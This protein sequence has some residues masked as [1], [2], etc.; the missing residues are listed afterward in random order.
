MSGQKGLWQDD[1][2]YSEGAPPPP[3]GDDKGANEAPTGPTTRCADSHPPLDV[4]GGRVIHGGS[5]TSPKVKDPSAVY[6]GFDAGMAAGIA[7]PWDGGVEV[8]FKVQDRDIPLNHARFKQL[9]TWV[10]EQLDAG[11]TVYAGCIGGHGRTGTFLSA[12]V[13]HRKASDDP[14]AYVRQHYCKKAVESSKQVAYLVSEWGCKSAEPTDHGGGAKKSSWGSSTPTWSGGHSSGVTWN[15]KSKPQ[16]SKPVWAP[17][18]KVSG[19]SSGKPLKIKAQIWG[20]HVI[21]LDW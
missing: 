19:K 1:P 16:K 4:G 11:R 9:V 18:D 21:P 15:G 12:L 8:L 3:P 7:W 2:Y 5:C 13:A 6:V 14:I 10:S 20:Q 17:P